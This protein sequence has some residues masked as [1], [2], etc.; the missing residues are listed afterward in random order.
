MINLPPVFPILSAAPAVTNIIGT[1]PVRCFLFGTAPQGT[2]QPY[3]VWSIPSRVPE[4]HLNKLPVVDFD[5][6]QLDVYAT[7]PIKCLELCKAIRDA[8]EPHGHMVLMFDMGKEETENLNRWVM[9]F[10]FWT[11]R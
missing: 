7:D 2:Q 11:A 3:V 6:V 9:D 1:K 4:N 5:R 10:N 8:L